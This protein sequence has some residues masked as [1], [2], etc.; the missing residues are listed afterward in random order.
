VSRCLPTPSTDGCRTGR[1]EQ[2]PDGMDD[3]GWIVRHL[4]GLDDG[5]GRSPHTHL[6]RQPNG[7]GTDG[8]R[9]AVAGRIETI[10]V[11]VAGSS[12]YGAVTASQ[13]WRLDG[14]AWVDGLATVAVAWAMVVRPFAKRRCPD[15]Q[16][17]VDRRWLVRPQRRS[18]RSPTVVPAWCGAG[19]HSEPIAGRSGPSSPDCC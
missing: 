9:G 13:G 17:T 1:Q 15:S 12:S 8:R 19:C 16:N 14:P 3:D 10:G 4:D 2:R 7:L 6:Q 5:G 11:T 18:F